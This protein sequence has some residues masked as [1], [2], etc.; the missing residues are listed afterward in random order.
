MYKGIHVKCSLLFFSDFNQSW[1]FSTDF[2]KIPNTK[3]RENPSSASR[4]VPKGRNDLR[5]DI[6]IDRQTWRS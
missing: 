6:Q 2:K 4:L 3:F 5:I 1:I